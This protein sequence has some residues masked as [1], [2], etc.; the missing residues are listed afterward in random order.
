[1]KHE[2][3]VLHIWEKRSKTADS[4]RWPWRT[5]KKTFGNATINRYFEVGTIN[6]INR[7]KPVNCRTKFTTIA[8]IKFVSRSLLVWDMGAF[9]SQDLGPDTCLNLGPGTG[10]FTIVQAYLV[11]FYNIKLITISR[12]HAQG[13]TASTRIPGGG[14]TRHIPTW[15]MTGKMGRTQQYSSTGSTLHRMHVRRS[16]VLP[17]DGGTRKFSNWYWVLLNLVYSSSV[18]HADVTQDLP[19][20][21]RSLERHWY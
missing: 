12:V 19:G 6:R 5:K 18:W 3:R 8:L 16:N 14:H 11:I 21:Q 9:S 20:M 15:L 7:L 4:D 1:M 10:N 13:R 2:V 17:R